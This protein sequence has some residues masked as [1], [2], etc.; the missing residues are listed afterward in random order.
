MGRMIGVTLV[1]LALIVLF[2]FIAG[3]AVS[4]L[5]AVLMWGAP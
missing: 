2:S 1:K 3:W 5:F 4:I